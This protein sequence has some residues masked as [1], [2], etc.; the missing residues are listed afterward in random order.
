MGIAL[1]DQLRRLLANGALVPG[2]HT[3]WHWVLTLT[4]QEIDSLRQAIESFLD[5]EDHSSND[6]DPADDPGVLATAAVIVLMQVEM[7]PSEPV[8]IPYEKLSEFYQNPRV[9]LI[10]EPLRRRGIVELNGIPR[11]TQ[12]DP[13]ITLKVT[14]SEEVQVAVPISLN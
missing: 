13:S 3:A 1:I 12:D 5:H 9:M 7:N 2:Q 14:T 6:S 8:S 4:D 10:L 11:M